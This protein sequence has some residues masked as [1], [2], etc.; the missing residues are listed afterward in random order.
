[1]KKIIAIAM[2]A[3]MLSGLFLTFAPK[4]DA[5]WGGG[6]GC[7]RNS[8]FNRCDWNRCGSGWN[9]NWGWNRC[10]CG[11]GGNWWF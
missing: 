6:W 8:C 7:R 2:S 11:G 10:G 1:M 4:A 5:N 9:N 3:I